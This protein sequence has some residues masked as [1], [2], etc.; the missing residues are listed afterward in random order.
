M[1]INKVLTTAV[2]V[3]LIGGAFAGCSKKDEG[4]SPSTSPAG[5]TAPSDN[6]STAPSTGNKTMNIIYSAEPPDLDSSKATTNASFTMINALNE[7]L[8]RLDKDGKA[9]PALAADMPQISADGLTYTIKLRDGVTFA[10]GTPVKASNFVEAYKRT[11]DPNTKALYAFMLEWIK[12]GSA[13]NKAKTAD[14]IKA[15]KDALGVKAKDD[16]TLEITLEKPVAFFT[17]QLAFP[18]FFPQQQ[19]VV[20]AAG[21][22]YGKDPDKVSGAGPFVLKEWKHEQSLTFV[23][24]PKYWDAANVKLDGFTVT[25]VK[26]RATSVNLFETGQGD[27]TTLGGEYVTKYQGKPEEQIKRELT[28][29]YMMY[30]QKKAP[31]LANKNIRQALTLG[32]D[33]AALVNIVLRNG[34]APATGLVPIGTSDGNNGDFRKTAGDTLAAFDAAKAKELFQKGLQELGLK[35]LPAFKI[36][37]DDTEGAK[38]TVEFILGQWKQNLGITTASADTVPHELRVERQDNKDFDVIIA[39]WGADYNDPMT[40][41]DMWTTTSSFNTMDYSNANYDKLIADAQNEADPAKRSQTLV[42]A[43]KL[44]MDDMAVGPLYFRTTVYALNPKVTGVIFPS[45]GSEWELKW[46]DV[47]K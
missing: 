33:R 16:Q 8:Y 40:F 3:T 11:L 12:G 25:I 30:E 5:S 34:S 32:I 23:K 2:A 20:D 15:A 47:Q 45:F 17:Q 28:N 35:E 24:N 10:D 44:L 4:A 22:T 26:D 1:K 38:K 46:V 9:T 13:V 42:E 18:L 31:F 29:A 43:E 7:G 19:S 14:E 41:L 27:L 6:S 21:D 36:T 39:L 37:A